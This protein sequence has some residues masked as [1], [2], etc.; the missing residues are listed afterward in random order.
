MPKKKTTPKAARATL[1]APSA[2]AA[3]AAPPPI[4]SAA[5]VPQPAVMEPVGLRTPTVWS[6]RDR[7][8]RPVGE[9]T[10][11]AT[12]VRGTS[13]T[14]SYSTGPLVLPNGKP[15]L[16]NESEFQRLAVAI[17]RV[18]FEDPSNNVRIERSIRKFVFHD[19]ATGEAIEMPALPDRE[20]GPYALSIADQAERDRIF[21]GQEHTAR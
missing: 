11:T 1:P 14:I 19:V 21:Q 4:P 6:P 17:D 8:P 12:L 16:I 20:V 5:P 10:R 13:W 18:D 7:N 3:R 15:I 2:E 9:L